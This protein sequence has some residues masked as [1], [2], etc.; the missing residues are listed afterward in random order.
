[1]RITG[2]S[3]KK[4]LNFLNN[5][6]IL[7]FYSYNGS[8]VLTKQYNGKSEIIIKGDVKTIQINTFL[9]WLRFFTLIFYLFGYKFNI[10][11]RKLIS[12]LSPISRIS[13]IPPF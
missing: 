12:Y 10:T 7:N 11:E 2:V 8:Y 4:Q 13:I 3:L 1:M 5:L 9:Y 6:L